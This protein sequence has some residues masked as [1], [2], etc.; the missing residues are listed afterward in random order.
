M[1]VEMLKMIKDKLYT[2]RQGVFTF[3][4]AKLGLLFAV[5]QLRVGAPLVERVAVSQ[6]VGADGH[7]PSIYSSMSSARWGWRI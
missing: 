4:Y 5:S 1:A 7:R 2:S 6:I 3:I